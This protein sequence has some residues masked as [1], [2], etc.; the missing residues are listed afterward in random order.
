MS[1]ND[2]DEPMDCS[3]PPPQSLDNCAESKVTDGAQVTLSLQWSD[4]P[5]PQRFDK[6]LEKAL[7]TWSN[8]NQLNRDCKVLSVTKDGRAVIKINPAPALSDLQKLCG[9]TL[10]F[11]D[12]N[13]VKIVHVLL[14]PPGQE[15]QIPDNASMNFPPQSMSQPQDVERQLREQSSDRTTSTCNI[16]PQLEAQI[17]DD[18]SKTPPPSSMTKPQDGK[19]VEQSSTSSSA[20][21]STTSEET[22]SATIAV[23]D[24][25]Y[26]Y[27]IYKEEIDRINKKNGVQIQAEVTVT[28]QADSQ[29]G[30]PQKAHKEFDSLAKRCSEES[31]GT[32]VPLENRGPEELKNALKIIQRKENKLLL[33][34]SSNEVIICGPSQSQNDVSKCFT[35]TKTMKPSAEDEESPWASQDTSPNIGM[36]IKDPLLQTGLHIEEMYWKLINTSYSQDLAKIKEKFGVDLKEADIGQGQVII[37]ARYRGVGGNASLESHALRALL[38]FYQKIATSPLNFTQHHGA[39]GFR[40]PLENSRDASEGASSG[41]VFNGQSGYNMRNTEAHTGEGAA[42]GDNEEE[43]CPICMDTFTKKTQLKCKHEFCEECLAQSVESL[44][45]VCPVCKDVFGKKEGNQ[46]EGR[47]TWKIDYISLPG[48]PRCG[49]ITINYHISGGKQTEKHPNP[50]QRYEGIFRE[51]YLPNNKEGKEVLHLLER[52]FEQKLTFTVGTSRTTG[53]ENQVTWN[54]IHHKT[55]KTGGQQSFGYPDPGYLSRVREELKALGIE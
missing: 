40:G 7:Q 11:K 12:G 1:G 15:I 49:T 3:G 4:G 31:N 38:H 46:P 37:K 30:N 10:D 21:V 50:G 29:N 22:C 23:S 13:A 18:P 8:H 43:T 34:L 36:N 2:T 32:S 33:T 47:M 39:A 5:Q 28:F 41:P 51:A 20:A 24:F 35:V 52:A 16:P 14:T 26:L 9:Q 27:H 48:F 54:D 45:P 25:W 53:R 55:S 44:G 17:A 19:P 42:A 6:K